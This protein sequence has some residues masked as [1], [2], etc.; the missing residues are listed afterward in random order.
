MKKTDES[1]CNAREGH[2]EVTLEI[3]WNE[4]DSSYVSQGY[5]FYND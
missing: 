4:E 1:K 2:Q 5:D 3:K